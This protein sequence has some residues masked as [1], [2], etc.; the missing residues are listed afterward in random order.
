MVITGELAMGMRL[1]AM[2]RRGRNRSSDQ[3]STAG[4]CHSFDLQSYPHPN[5]IKR[6]DCAV[7][8]ATSQTPPPASQ[9]KKKIEDV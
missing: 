8:L 9:K 5:K 2:W 7:V 1:R 4:S 3:D 6:L